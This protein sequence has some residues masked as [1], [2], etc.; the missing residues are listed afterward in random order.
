MRWS[1]S[2]LKEETRNLWGRSVGNY[3]TGGMSTQEMVSMSEG[4]Q[5]VA[6]TGVERHFEHCWSAKARTHFTSQG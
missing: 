2:M 3:S 6:N 5:M 1:I 4:G